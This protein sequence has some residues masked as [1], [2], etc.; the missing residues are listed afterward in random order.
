MTGRQAY[1]ADCKLRP[2]Y[3]R[4]GKP[5]PKWD[6]LDD[7]AQQSWI[8]SPSPREWKPLPTEAKI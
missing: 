3:G 5:R 6:D 7:I 8:K 4:S 1:E 2:N